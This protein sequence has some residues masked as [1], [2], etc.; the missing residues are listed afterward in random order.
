MKY[1]IEWPLYVR[2]EMFFVSE[3]NGSHGGI[4]GDGKFKFYI[5][6]FIY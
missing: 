5:Y 2:V 6:L 1:E 3:D 4:G